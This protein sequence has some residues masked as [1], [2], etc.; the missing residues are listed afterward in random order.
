M[1]KT[2]AVIGGGPAGMMAAYAAK[3]A[4]GDEAEVV[5]YERNPMLGKKLRITG[6]GRCNVTNNCTPAEFREAVTRNQKFL[7]GASSRFT[8]ADTMA[9]FE[10]WGVPLKTERGRRVFPVSDKAADIAAAMERALTE[11]GVKIYKGMHISRLAAEDNS[12]G[13][14]EEYKSPISFRCGNTVHTCDALILATGGVSYPGTGSTGDGHRMLSGMDIPVTDLRPSLVPIETKEKTGEL[15]G[16]TLK[17]VSLTAYRGEKEVFSEQGEMLFAHFGLTGPL[18]LSASANMQKGSVSD[19]RLTIDLKPALTMEELDKRLL[20]DFAKYSARDFCNSLDDLLPKRLIPWVIRVSGIPERCKTASL[21]KV[22]RQKLC[23]TLK[24]LPFTPTKF[25]PMD[26]AIITCGG[27]DVSAVSPKDMM[28]KK[29]PGVFCAGELLDLDAYTGGYNLQIA[30]S[31]GVLA[32][33]G[34]A[35]F[36]MNSELRIKN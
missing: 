24:A 10:S 36:V 8:S 14:G 30:F 1:K 31:T 22:Q 15:M 6:R 32:G 7:Y 26:E 3:K 9:F 23:E 12:A 20:S 4:C 16:L 11:T 19:Y 5:L 13:D 27:V 18:V 33:Q 29:L 17:N 35:A 25:R 28:L 2:I 34:A 21:T